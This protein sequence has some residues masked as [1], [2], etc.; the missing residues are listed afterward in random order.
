[1]ALPFFVWFS[2]PAKLALFAGC[3]EPFPDTVAAPAFLTEQLGADAAGMCIG[4]RCPAAKRSNFTL[5]GM[6]EKSTFSHDV[7]L[8]SKD[9]YSQYNLWKV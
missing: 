1:M 7:G 4:R 6:C 2:W 8:L 9:L 3:G 5:H